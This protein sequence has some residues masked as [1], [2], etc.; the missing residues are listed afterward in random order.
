MPYAKMFAQVGAT[1]LAAVIAALTGDQAIGVDE[2]LIIATVG[3]GAAAVF[4]G[5]NI[6]GAPITKVV[7]SVLAAILGA[8]VSAIT[9]G[10]TVTEWLMLGMAALGALGVYAVP[11]TASPAPA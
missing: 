1:I 10:I 4:T 5:P 7:L 11:N 6:A 3:V 9:G 8:L 2:W